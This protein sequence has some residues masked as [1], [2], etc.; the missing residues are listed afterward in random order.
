VSVRKVRRF[1]SAVT[2][3]AVLAGGLL[4]FTLPKTVQTSSGPVY[5]CPPGTEPVPWLFPLILCW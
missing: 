3:S 2:L 4:G 1:L 5:A